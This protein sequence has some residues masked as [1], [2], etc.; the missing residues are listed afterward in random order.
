MLFYHT[1]Q[2]SKIVGVDVFNNS[3]IQTLS[4]MKEHLRGPLRI[5]SFFYLQ[6]QLLTTVVR[7]LLSVVRCLLFVV[8]GL[9]SFQCFSYLFNVA[10]AYASEVAIKFAFNETAVDKVVYHMASAPRCIASLAF[11]V[12]HIVEHCKVFGRKGY[13]CTVI[14]QVCSLASFV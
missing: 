14:G 11:A 7:C 8:L 4:G 6:F 2:I 5:V 9:L 12:A 10:V 1:V 3:N 13:Y